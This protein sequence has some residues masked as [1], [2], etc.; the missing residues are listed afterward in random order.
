IWSGPRDGES[1]TC[2]GKRKRSEVHS[3]LTPRSVVG[4]TVLGRSAAP[5]SWRSSRPSSSLISGVP[6]RWCQ[7]FRDLRGVR[8]SAICE[9]RSY[10]D[11]SLPACPA[12]PICLETETD[13]AQLPVASVL[14]LGFPVPLR[15]SH[16][17]LRQPPS[18]FAAISSNPTLVA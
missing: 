16:R 11:T 18:Q 15:P 12:L 6:F 2:C 5:G 7:D 10:I 8:T 9:G 13:P 17:A 3:A 1:R 4:L 14:P